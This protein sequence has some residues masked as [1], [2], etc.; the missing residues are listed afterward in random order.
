MHVRVFRLPPAPARS[1]T[2]GH[3]RARLP[4]KE[5]RVGVLS[6]SHSRQGTGRRVCF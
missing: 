6:L 5:H 2:R 3:C 1:Q 4:S